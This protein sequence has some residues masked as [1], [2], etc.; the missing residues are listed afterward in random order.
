MTYAAAEA[1]ERLCRDVGIAA[2]YTDAWGVT[3]RATAATRLSLLRAMDV[4]TR[5]EEAEAA[6][7][8]REAAPWRRLLPA[9]AVF[10]EDEAPYRLTL[11]VEAD[12]MG[13]KHRWT[14]TLEDGTF[15]E[16]EFLPQ[17]LEQ[18]G[19]REIDGTRHVKVVFDW[20]ERLP[21]GYHRFTLRQG[22]A[23][24]PDSTRLI[25]APGECFLP[26]QIRGGVRAWGPALQLYA[27]RSGRSW[28]M[29]DY[30]DLRT[31]VAQWSRCGA[32]IFGLNP[33]HALFPHNPAHASPYSPS[34]RLFLNI[35]YIDVVA[36]EDYG[37]S[38]EAEALAGNASF[39]HEIGR[40]QDRDFIDYPGVAAA[41]LPVLQQL[42]SSFRKNHLAH[43]T[44]RAQAFRRFQD[45]GGRAL[46]LHAL[47]EALQDHFHRADTS[48]WGWPAWPAAYHDP[49][50]QEVAAFAA[51]HATQIEFYQ[52][53]QWLASLQLG[54]AAEEA[55]ARGAI[56]LYTDLAVSIDRG[57][58]DAWTHQEHY[59]LHASVGAPPDAFNLKG[60]DWGLPPIRPDRL[61][62]AA[63]EP[64]IAMLRANMQHAGALRIDHVMGL[65]RLFWIPEGGT[66][67]DGTY[68][69]YPHADLLRILAL[70]SHRQRCMVIGE[71]LG[72]V[73]DDLRGS[74]ERRNVLSYRLLYFERE[75]GGDFKPPA[76]Y[77]RGALVACSTHD[78]PTLAGFWEGRDLALRTALSLFPTDAARE[79]LTAERELDRA[80]LL[81][82]LEREG[83]LP[84][85]MSAGPAA[86][87]RMTVALAR[88]IHIFLART[89]AYV[90]MVQP[91]DI[92]GSIEQANLPGTTVEHPNWQRRL[93]LPV[94][95]FAEDARFVALGQ[96]ITEARGGSLR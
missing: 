28:G 23:A 44:P 80:R 46:R 37:E 75:A 2:E 48:V 32:G 61:Q 72:T 21:R 47:F 8:R 7:A 95:G 92:L 14:L 33:L 35:L 53:A 85:G 4:L 69:H 27:L 63:Y 49:H 11:H 31:V 64:F 87:P 74:L 93:P 3:R 6:L 84:P 51:S 39:Q 9:V 83:L 18:L 22:D 81:R 91:E 89:P 25:I 79:V 30:G 17:Q 34:S 56:G 41:K 43:A 16:G 5:E 45:E 20:R 13:A 1:L 38:Q 65:A 58:S 24:V 59:A 78:L 94:E 67:T 70:E 96:A 68:V 60:Q 77:P 26:P 82:A 36:V 40:L 90:M 52:Y 73:P 29:G 62:E 86:V 55:A 54:H 50:S 66:A 12:A 71:D 76:A 15:R 42:Y 10:S 57:G 88:A 19:D